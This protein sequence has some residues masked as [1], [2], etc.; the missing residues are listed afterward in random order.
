M[1]SCPRYL[2][3]AANVIRPL[4]FGKLTSQFCKLIGPTV[5]CKNQ[6]KR[7]NNPPFLESK[8]YLIRIFRWPNTDLS[9][10]HVAH[11]QKQVLVAFTVGRNLRTFSASIQQK[12]VPNYNTFSVLSR[13][14]TSMSI[15]FY[16][17]VAKFPQNSYWSEIF[18]FHAE[19]FPPTKRYRI[20][21]TIGVF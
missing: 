19:N 9:S 6:Q 4:H 12:S 17:F 21:N 5:F 7:A 8:A 11:L 3:A 14:S 2:T 16:Y 13:L 20:E 10:T 15:K 1:F 18:H